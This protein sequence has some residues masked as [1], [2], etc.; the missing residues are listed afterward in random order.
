MKACILVGGLGTRLRSAVV[1]RPK[2][3]ALI[4]NKPFLAFVLDDLAEQGFEKIIF[5]AHYKWEIIQDYFGYDYHGMQISYVIEDELLG[6]G[7]AIVNAVQGIHD[8]IFILN[9][10]TFVKLDY[11]AMY[12]AFLVHS[13]SEKILRSKHSFN[14]PLMLA[15][16][17]TENCQRY[18]KVLIDENAQTKESIITAFTEKGGTNRGWINAGVYLLHPSIF[19]HYSLEKK[20]SFERDFLVP[21]IRQIKPLA[22]IASGYFIDIGVPTD[23]QKAIEDLT[24][25]AD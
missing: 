21:Y 12:T 8:P 13:P 6:T 11:Q 4:G 23:Y 15:V 25:R 24:A 10:D 9:G 2:P 22:Y 16:Q 17:E 7:G 14:F 18:G 5:S 1:D 19:S 3:M 20:F